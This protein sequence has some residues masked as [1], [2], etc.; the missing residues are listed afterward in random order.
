MDQHAKDLEQQFN[1][2]AKHMGTDPNYRVVHP[3]VEAQ[4]HILEEL[5]QMGYRLHLEEGKNARWA[6]VAFTTKERQALA[7]EGVYVPKQGRIFRQR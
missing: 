7:K 3:M 6:L 1:E 4:Q 2:I 5:Q